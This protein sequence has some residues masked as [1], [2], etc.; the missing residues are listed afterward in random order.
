M[1]FP[2]TAKL[3]KRPRMDVILK[4]VDYGTAVGLTRGAKLGQSAVQGSLRSK[5]TI[6]NNWLEQ[7]TPLGIKIT[8]ATP[9]KLRSEVKTAARFLPL[10]EKGGTKIPFGNHLAIPTKNVRPNP[11]ALIPKNLMPKALVATGKAFVEKFKNGTMALSVHGLKKSGKFS[12]VVVMYFLVP[13]AQIKSVD[14]WEGPIE[15]V[16]R[17]HLKSTIDREIVSALKKAR[18]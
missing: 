17:I 8:P 3:V 5:F 12:D 11:R 10:Q 9:A 16:L 2:I 14:F 7:Q 1:S 18:F 13:R 4:Q 15:S 6:R